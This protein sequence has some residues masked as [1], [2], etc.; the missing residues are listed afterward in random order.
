VRYV[1]QTLEVAKDFVDELFSHEELVKVEHVVARRLQHLILVVADGCERQHLV[2][3]VELGVRALFHLLLLLGLSR[4]ST[5]HLVVGPRG[6]ILIVEAAPWN[7][8]LLFH[9]RFVRFFLSEV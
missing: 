4:R 7:E 1:E 9:R 5:C 3:D 6:L 2:Q 8:L